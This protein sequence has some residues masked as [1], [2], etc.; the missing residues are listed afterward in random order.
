MKVIDAGQRLSSA[1]W[2]RCSLAQLLHSRAAHGG[3]A[4]LAR[5]VRGI[6]IDL[7][8]IWQVTVPTSSA[9]YLLI[10][11]EIQAHPLPAYSAD[12]PKRY[13]LMRSRRQR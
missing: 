9:A 8:R 5:R 6:L 10:R 4:S 7:A 13:S 2:G 1:G 3:P 12:L 11:R